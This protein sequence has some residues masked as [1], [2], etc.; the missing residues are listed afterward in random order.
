[1]SR[2]ADLVARQVAPHAC[3]DALMSVDYFEERREMVAAIRVIAQHL[4]AEVG[5]TVLD[6]RVLSAMAKV[7]RHEF[8]PVESGPMLT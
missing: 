7:A 2:S 1:V 8:V 5:K 6:D 3:Y 4:A